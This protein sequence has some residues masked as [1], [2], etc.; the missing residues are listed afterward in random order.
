MNCLQEDWGALSEV[1]E[2]TGRH[3]GGST[4]NGVHKES[5]LVQEASEVEGWGKGEEGGQVGTAPEAVSPTL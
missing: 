3:Q 5:R 2:E 1:K 4:E